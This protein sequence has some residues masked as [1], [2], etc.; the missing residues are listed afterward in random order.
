MRCFTKA[1]KCTSCLSLLL[2]LAAAFC[3]QSLGANLPLGDVNIVVITDDHSWVGGHGAHESLDVDYGDVL[4]FYERLVNATDEDVFLIHN[5]DWGDGTGLTTYPPVH[6]EPILLKMPWH[7]V[8]VGNHDIYKNETVVHMTR[9]GG[10]I[11][12]LGGRYLT[13][14]VVDSA[15]GK[16]LGHRYRYLRGK[17]TTVLTF[18]FIY[19][20]KAGIGSPLAIVERVKN[21]VRQEW[22]LEVL[23]KGGYDAI[24]VL[25]H[26]STH[27]SSVKIILS[28]IRNETGSAMPVQFITGHTHHRR[29]QVL[30]DA[31]TAVEAGCYLDTVGFV[32]FPTKETGVSKKDAAVSKLFR[33]ELMDAKV[34][35]LKS[36]LGVR[37]LKTR[38]GQALTDFILKTQESMGLSQIVGCSPRTF[39]L[40]RTL[41][42]DD[43]LFGVWARQVIPTHFIANDSKRVVLQGKSSSFR[44]DLFEGNV[45]LD[46]LMIVSPFNDSMY[47]IASDIPTATIVKLNRTMNRKRKMDLSGLPD[48]LL[49][50]NLSASPFHDLY[51][52]EYEVPFIK[53]A[54][55]EISGSQLNPKPVDAYATSLWRSFVETSWQNCLEQ[56]FS[57]IADVDWMGSSIYGKKRKANWSSASP[58]KVA[59]FV[60]IASASSACVLLGRFVLRRLPGR[61]RSERSCKHVI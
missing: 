37:K 43:S 41:Y 9:A 42:D 60:A 39:Y 53:H 44:Y 19:N 51:T 34:D 49:I 12:K 59:L 10:F 47:L 21:V 14:N 24:L 58:G 2:L 4:S 30:D 31:S 61:H 1:R 20:I 55:E 3:T 6:L 36:R 29:H 48:F 28:A 25:A 32:S 52:L 27:S 35:V 54:L 15:S 16:P 56:E 33:H 17:D 8:N 57:N 22:F 46:D 26:M 11:D 5:G 23:R 18:G 13:S 50:G 45:T 38:N 7:A 40:K